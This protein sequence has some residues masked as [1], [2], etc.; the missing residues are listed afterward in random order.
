M[1]V[2]APPAL[3][4]A[5]LALLGLL[6]PFPGL[7]RAEDPPPTALDAAR[8]EKIREIRK[9]LKQW[10][11]GPY[12]EKHKDE[13]FTALE[14]LESLGGVEAGR[15]ALE[16]VVFADKDVRDR[17]FL[18]AEKEHDKAL[19]APLGALLDEKDMRR[20]WDLRKRVAH[21][22]AVMAHDSA[23]PF[24]TDLVQG[25]DAHVVAAA[26][27]ALATYARSPVEAKREPVQRM[28]DLYESTWNM[29]NSMKR[30]DVVDAKVAREKYE[31]FGKALKQALQAMT[32]QS[33][34][35]PQEWRRWWNDHKKDARWDAGPAPGG[36]GGGNR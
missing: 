35:R 13:I 5:V 34:T 30:E 11:S 15:A 19:V 8:K 2:R 1:S 14:A 27:D 22:L 12:G 36:G 17:A 33:I 9:D 4:P 3:L 31:I 29:M 21:A 24:L 32:G 16:A 28:I 10:C 25:E 6:A 23:L 26:A 20:D 7:A 18:I